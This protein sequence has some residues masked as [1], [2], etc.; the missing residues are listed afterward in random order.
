MQ[1]YLMLWKLNRSLI[2]VN[3]QERGEA[4]A[5]LMSL[6]QQDIEVGFTK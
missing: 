5:L 6:V 3:P 4:F 2:P 1:K